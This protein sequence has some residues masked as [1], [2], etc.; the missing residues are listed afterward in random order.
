MRDCSLS[1]C[2]HA[3]R[4]QQ[5]AASGDR[6]DMLALD[7]NAK[8]RRRTCGMPFAELVESTRVDKFLLRGCSCK[9]HGRDALCKKHAADRE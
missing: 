4:R 6:E 3:R 1:S 9:P 8:L 5:F 7:G 2:A